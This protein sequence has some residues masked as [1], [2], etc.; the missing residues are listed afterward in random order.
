MFTTS[1]VRVGPA[2]RRAALGTLF[3]VAT[4]FAVLWLA[5]AFHRKIAP[6]ARVELP[7]APSGAAVEVRRLR[8]PRVEAA[9]GTV[10]AVSETAVA[11][12]LLA[13]VVEVTRQAGAAVERDEVLVRLDDEDLRARLRQAESA[14]A[15]AAALL[16]QAQIE[17]D[18]VERLAA[19][20]SAARIELDR[21]ATALRTAKAEAERAVQ[22]RREAETTLA[23]ATIRS[24]LGGIV[25]D[26]T[27]EPGDTVTPG[28]TLMKVHDPAHMQLVA[29][30]RESLTRRLRVGQDVPVRIDALDLTC[31]GR[32]S[33]IVPEADPASRSF[34]V[35]V[36]GPCPPGAY[37]G[38]F[39][40]L[41]IPLDEEE[42]LVI[43]RAAVR[44]VGQLDLV[45]VV[46][47]DAAR[48]RAVRLGR[49]FGEEIEVLSGLRLGERV[50]VA[51]GSAPAADEAGRP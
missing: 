7:P 31:E 45:D 2:A 36:T 43:P 10:R 13:R 3:V 19:Q 17:W 41:L 47:D 8:V 38:M 25:V 44:R 16:E 48:R 11:S 40:R 27:V 49:E 21:A 14:A 15:G 50:L 22:A 24:P 46:A 18:R 37:S 28:Q 29:S 26:R 4:V 51:P 5:G 30:V 39:G 34:T 23:Y 32:V 6:A 35:K 42:V 12:K 9:V 1:R 33:E 20:D